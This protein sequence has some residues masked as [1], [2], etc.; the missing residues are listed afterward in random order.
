MP[1]T[2]E[3]RFNADD[4]IDRKGRVILKIDTFN[5]RDRNKVAK[6]VVDPK[7]SSQASSVTRQPVA[8][9]KSSTNSA[10]AKEQLDDIPY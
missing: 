2:V 3:D 10:S 9:S 4:A 1:L 6:Y 7:A 5:G 8:V